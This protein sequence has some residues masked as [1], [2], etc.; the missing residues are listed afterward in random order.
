MGPT[1]FS[2]CGRLAALAPALALAATGCSAPTFAPL[3][4]AP[5]QESS[6]EF[7]ARYWQAKPDGHVDIEAGAQPV[8]S[9]HAGLSDQLGLDTERELLWSASIDLGEHRFGAEYLPL[10]FGGSKS[11][12]RGFTFHGTPFPKGE[13]VSTDFDLETWV[14]KWDY[15]LS[16]E[17]RTADA[18]RV[19]LGAWW[20]NLDIDVKGQPSG[21]RESREWSRI[22][23]GVHLQQTM[24]LGDGARLEIFGALAA[25]SY[26]RR[27]YDLGA[28]LTYAV[29]DAIAL[30]VGYRWMIWDFNETTNDGDFDF[31][32]PLAN[33]TVRF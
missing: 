4:L 27:L 23:P 32:G 11:I 28:D 2:S 9:T 12:T 16:K 7:T 14:F 1:R 31:S 24:A 8:T 10:G 30:G 19:G 5:R 17:K 3:P 13:D 18:F 26:H 20:W 6:I 22:Y 29:S 21:A 25:N 15:A 33:L